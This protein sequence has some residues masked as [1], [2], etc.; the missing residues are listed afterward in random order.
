MWDLL[1][2]G[3]E[4][5]SPGLAGGFFT[6]ELPGKPYWAF[7]LRRKPFI[8]AVYYVTSESLPAPGTILGAEGTAMNLE[9]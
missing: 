6:T 7:T 8:H 2:S 3:I 5:M 1:K 9:Q 4:P